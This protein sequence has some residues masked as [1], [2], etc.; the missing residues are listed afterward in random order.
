MREPGDRDARTNSRACRAAPTRCEI[1]DGTTTNYFLTTFGRSPRETVCAC[2]VRTEPTLSQ[3]LHLINGETVE[4]KITAG[5]VVSRMLAE[6]KTPAEILRTLYIRCYVPGALGRRIA[7]A[8]GAWSRGGS[9]SGRP[10]TTCS[11]PF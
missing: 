4:Q 8:A 5:G 2:E 10:W 1:A 11:G 6:K 7:T 3:A 9:R